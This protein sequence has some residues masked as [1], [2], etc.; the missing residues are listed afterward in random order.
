MAQYW[1]PAKRRGWG[2]GPPSSWQGWVALIVFIALVIAGSLF[3][4]PA[5]H[6]PIYLAYVVLLST[7][8]IAICWW[9]GEPPHWRRNGNSQPPA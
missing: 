6:L 3:F 1:F 9:K 7:G 8:F 5:R 4:P 2:W